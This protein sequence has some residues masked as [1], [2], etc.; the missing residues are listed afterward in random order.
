VRVRVRIDGWERSSTAA[1]WSPTCA[2]PDAKPR[3]TTGSRAAPRPREAQHRKLCSWTTLSPFSAASTSASLRRRAR[4]ADLAVEIRVRS[5]PGSERSCATSRPRDAGTGAVLLSGSAA[6][7]SPRRYLKAIGRATKRSPWRTPT[8]CPTATSS[9]RSKRPHI[10]GAGA[11][12]ARWPHRPAAS[13]HRDAATVPSL[14]GAGVEIY[15]WN[16][17]VLHAKAPRRRRARAGGSF[18]SSRSRS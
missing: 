4:V 2:P 17:T 5:A 7:A 10:A 3:S 1:A 11:A 9:D 6:V 13:A 16:R 15:E 14:L 8:S 18:N 12:P